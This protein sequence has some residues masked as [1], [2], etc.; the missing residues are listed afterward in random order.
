MAEMIQANAA[1]L[2]AALIVLLLVMWFVI[3]ANRKARIQRD[4]DAQDA[5]ARRN[6]ALID[7]PPAVV[8][9]TIPPPVPEAAPVAAAAAVTQTTPAAA[10]G[11]DLT[12]IKGLGPKIAAQLAGM[13]ITSFAQIAAWDD[14]EIDRVDALMGRFAGRIRRDRWVEQARLLAA[15]DK[16]GFAAHFG[17]G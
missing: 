17:N 16:A 12:Q 4:S 5:Q 1:L 8:K 3:A 9:E 15:G 13:G 11:D 14:A 7:A 2:V 10:S 6:Q